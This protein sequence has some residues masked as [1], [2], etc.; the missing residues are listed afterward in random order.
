MVGVI[1]P[2]RGCGVM[3]THR[4]GGVMVVGS[5]MVEMAGYHVGGVMVEMAR[6]H[7]GGVPCG[8]GTMWAGSW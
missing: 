5:V 3:V 6:Y 8:R 1:V 2:K 7:V 4:V